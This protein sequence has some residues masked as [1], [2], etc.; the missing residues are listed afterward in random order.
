LTVTVPDAVAEQLPPS[1][2]VTKYVVLEV[3]LTV[4]LCVK[5]PVFQE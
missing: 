1:V 3:G 5:A 2:T 4:M